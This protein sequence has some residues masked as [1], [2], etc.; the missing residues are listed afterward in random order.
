MQVTA[1]TQ[2]A[3]ALLG[4]HGLGHAGGCRGATF[5][6]EPTSARAS[7][8]VTTGEA[9]VTAARDVRTSCPV[10]AAGAGQMPPI[11]TRSSMRARVV[12]SEQT[13]QLL[14]DQAGQ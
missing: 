11:S 3:Q 9:A 7:A 13:Q 1:R 12:F 8:A 10:A 2:C 5:V 14:I 6:S 4:T